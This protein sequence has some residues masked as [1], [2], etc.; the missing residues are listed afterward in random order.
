MQSAIDGD[1]FP[2][3]A[4][5]SHLDLSTLI[6]PQTPL[7]HYICTLY[8]PL[9][10]LLVDTKLP[11]TLKNSEGKTPLYFAIQAKDALATYYCLQQ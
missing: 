4:A 1:I 3:V 6:N 7:S 2:L 9:E 10:T 8:I 11:I 5:I